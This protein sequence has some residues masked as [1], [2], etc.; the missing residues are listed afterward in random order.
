[1]FARCLGSKNKEKE[2][3]GERREERG[4]RS[5]CLLVV[6]APRRKRKKRKKRERERKEKGERRKE[7][8]LGFGR[9]EEQRRQT[10]IGDQIQGKKLRTNTSLSVGKGVWVMDPLIPARKFE[11]GHSKVPNF[12]F[13]FY[14]DMRSF[15]SV[16]F[17]V[18]E[19]GN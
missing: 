17:G 3:R 4:E 8:K 15:L 2:E 12:L 19:V 7:K 9:E 13:R 11:N 18:F 5:S 10:A 1:M 16:R 6:W 14:L